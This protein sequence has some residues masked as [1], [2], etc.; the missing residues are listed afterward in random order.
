MTT[1]IKSFNEWR[2]E[3]ELFYDRMPLWYWN[4]AD[5][6]RE[7]DRYVFA[8]RKRI[9]EKRIKKA[10]EIFST[11]SAVALFYLV[12]VLAAYLLAAE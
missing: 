5:R 6:I 3:V 8:A 7:Y 1:G 9:N 4:S 11:I 12:M 2:D 10:R